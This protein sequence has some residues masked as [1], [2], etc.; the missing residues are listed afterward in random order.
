MRT[1]RTAG[2]AVTAAMALG[3]AAPA[4]ADT[5]LIQVLSPPKLPAAKKVS[6]IVS[7][8]SAC[9]LTATLTLKLP[10]P[11]LGPVTVGPE[12]FA[13]GGQGSPFLILNAPAKRA[14]KENYKRARLKTTIKAVN[15]DPLGGGATDTVQRVF[16]FKRK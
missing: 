5:G 11:D 10:G 12:T 16:R 4:T 1:R 3:L 6:Y 9:S 7:C 13:A 15:L 2:L 14:L 8:T